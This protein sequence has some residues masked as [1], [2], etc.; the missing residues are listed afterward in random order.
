MYVPSPLSVTGDI[1]P[2]VVPSATV[3]PPVWRV[4]PKTSLAVTVTV[5]VELPSAV[6]VVGATASVEWA[7]LAA[8]API[9]NAA[10]C[11]DARLVPL[12]ASLYPAEA[13]S[14][15]RSPNVATPAT[16]L[17]LSVPESVAPAAPVP[18]AIAT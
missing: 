14:S 13:L 17:W 12:A 18:P 10:L 15:E 7:A 2:R 8:P 6:T 11:A 5:E 3:A 16:A 1:V 4:L 9:E